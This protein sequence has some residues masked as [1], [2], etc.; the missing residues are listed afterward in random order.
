VE[1][2]STRDLIEALREPGES[3]EDLAARLPISLSTLN[4]WKRAAPRDW[5]PILE[6][7]DRAG[8]LKYNGAATARAEQPLLDDPEFAARLEELA[9][10]LERLLPLVADRM[11]EQRDDV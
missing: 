1:Q 5:Y 7:L 3:Y 4:R 2:P 6:M 11:R 8:W 9:A 10:L